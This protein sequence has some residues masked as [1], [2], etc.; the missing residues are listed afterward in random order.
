MFIYLQC[1]HVRVQAI[2]YQAANLFHN[3]IT[4][5]KIGNTNA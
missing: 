5:L 3:F 1:L 2:I 4:M